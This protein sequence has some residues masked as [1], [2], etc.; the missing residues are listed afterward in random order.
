M[1]EAIKSGRPEFI[2]RFLA[3]SFLSKKQPYARAQ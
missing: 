3:K 1:L 2:G